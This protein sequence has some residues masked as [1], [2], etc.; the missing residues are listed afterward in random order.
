MWKIKSWQWNLFKIKSVKV[1]NIKF[2][3]LKSHGANS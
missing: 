2:T 1:E 3:F